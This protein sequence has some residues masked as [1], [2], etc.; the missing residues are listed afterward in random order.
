MIT[1]PFRIVRPGVDVWVIFQPFSE[2][3]KMVLG[4]RYLKGTIN[5]SYRA[6]IAVFRVELA[7]LE[8]IAAEAG[9]SEIRHAGGNMRHFFHDYESLPTLRNGVRKRL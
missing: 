7:R 4:L 2:D 8:R 6:M 3:G 1:E 9:F 5:L